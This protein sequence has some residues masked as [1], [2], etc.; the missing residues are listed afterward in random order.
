MPRCASSRS[1][2]ARSRPGLS[3]HAGVAA[4]V[5]GD[6][7][8]DQGAVVGQFP[9]QGLRHRSRRTRRVKPGPG[10][11][12]VGEEQVVG[13][14]L[15]PFLV[16]GLHQQVS[17]HDHTTDGAPRKWGPVGLNVRNFRPEFLGHPGWVSAV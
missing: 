12:E 11:H 7:Q 13:P 17:V 8:P 2:R 15:V 6:T 14:F 5:E 9:G 10:V 16:E 4:D 1:S 3:N